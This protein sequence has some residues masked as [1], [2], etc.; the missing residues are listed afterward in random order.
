MNEILREAARAPAWVLG[1]DW[2][3]KPARALVHFLR[4]S[5]IGWRKE[6]APN[7]MK[8][9]LDLADVLG[10]GGGATAGVGSSTAIVTT[11]AAE[12][13]SGAAVLTSGLATLGGGSMALG[14]GV[15]AA[16]PIG[17]AAA[18]YGAVQ[19]ARAIA[20]YYSAPAKKKPKWKKIRSGKWRKSY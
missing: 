1:F 12:G 11:L 6:T 10:I 3:H 14:I 5:H 13:T 2:P 16:I 18:C 17:T 15:A 8:F 4:G 20:R 19:G 7:S 9:I